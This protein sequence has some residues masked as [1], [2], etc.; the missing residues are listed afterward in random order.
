MSMPFLHGITR[1]NEILLNN[2]ML[3]FINKCFP[4]TDPRYMIKFVF[5]CMGYVVYL[6]IKLAN[7]E[8]FN[9]FKFLLKMFSQFMKLF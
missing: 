8:M 5:Q 1:T 4:F 7:E 3:I 6:I 2:V 9:V